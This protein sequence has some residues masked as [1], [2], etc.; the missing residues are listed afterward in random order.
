MAVPIAF[1]I[2]ATLLFELARWL[3]R[4]EARR[5]RRIRKIGVRR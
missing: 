4:P 1:V 3:F 5:L 2:G